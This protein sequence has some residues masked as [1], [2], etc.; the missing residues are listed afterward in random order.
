MRVTWV[1]QAFGDYRVPVYAQLDELLGGT[2]HVVYSAVRTHP[3]VH[4]KITDLLG[5][6]AVALQ[7]ERLLLRTGNS[8]S[9]FSNRS[10]EIPFQPGLASAIA[11][12][13]PDVVIGEGFAKWTA[14]ALFQRA[15]HGTPLVV[16]YQRT[17][18]TE[19]HAQ[20]F[21]QAYRRMAL[22]L[23]D[24]ICCNGRLSAE[25]A[26]WLGMP[27]NRIVTGACAAD[28]EV[29]ATKCAA[30]T[31]EER[32]ARKSG[33]GAE[34]T[35]FLYVGRLIKLKGVD[36]LLRGWAAACVDHLLPTSSLLVVGDGPERDRLC[37]LI[38]QLGLRNVRLIGQVDYDSLAA[39]YAIAD[40]LVMPTLEDNW[41]LVVPEAMA[42]GLPI[43]SS[44]YNGCWPELVHDN[45]NGF[46][47][48]PF[49]SACLARHLAF[50]ARHPDRIRP[51]GEA[52]RRI[53][54]DFSPR[55]AAESFLRACRLAS[56]RRGRLPACG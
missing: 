47:F 46:V 5:R 34:G 55:S 10:L 1:N 2:L 27:E 51:M 30:V 53:V 25:Y 23:V 12:T 48:D 36:L 37:R 8:A 32:S 24:V 19:R 33:I 26:R 6:R 42:C 49:D 17:H 28:N 56:S 29:L 7:G 44:V 22:R 18:H 41:S 16:A 40:V 20:W 21:R 52:S 35:V 15:I 4:L 11:A 38:D 54:A 3:R 14:A 13:K 9:G 43:L 39:Y 31:Q 50:F 45:V